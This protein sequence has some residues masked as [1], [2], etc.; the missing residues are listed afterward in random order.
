M[1]CEHDFEFIYP[2][3]GKPT[4]YYAHMLCKKCGA[5]RLEDRDEHD[6]CFR[7]VMLQE[8]G[9]IWRERDGEPCSYETYMWGEEE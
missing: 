8:D 2:T 7:A 6:Y 1:K 3:Y 5:P 4:G 9:E